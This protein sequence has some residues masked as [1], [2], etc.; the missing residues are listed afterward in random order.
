MKTH[1]RLVLSGLVLAVSCWAALRAADPIPAR[2]A[3]QVLVLDNERTLTGKIDREGD[4]Y[5]VRRKAGETLVP[6]ANVLLLCDSFEEAYKFLCSRA[7][8][9]DPDERLKLAR[10]CQLHGLKDQALTEAQAAGELRPD[11]PEYQRLLQSLQRTAK[12]AVPVPPPSSS[13]VPAAGLV[14]SPN[15]EVSAETMGHFVK[16]VQPILMNTCASCHMSGRAGAFKLTRAFEDGTV[17]RRATQQNLNAVLAQ[18]NREKWVESPFLLRAVSVHGPASQPPL[19]GRQS[20]AFRALEE[21]VRRAVANNPQLR[22]H[23][24]ATTPAEAKGSGEFHSAG[25]PPAAPTKSGTAPTAT[26]LP[27]AA[28]VDPF[29]PAIF[30]RQKKPLGK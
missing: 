24:V 20:P 29:D 22:E 10:W 8:L 7:N 21:W 14:P 13:P 16:K 15:I 19:K 30:N 25:S 4:Q 3:G 6:S 27:L 18:I 11:N 26:P 2:S 12:P 1:I 28:P 17:N 23:S 5:R 9:R